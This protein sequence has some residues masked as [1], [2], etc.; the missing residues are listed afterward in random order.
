MRKKIEEHCILNKN[1]L[2]KFIDYLELLEVNDR[3]Y[4]SKIKSDLL[5]D[6]KKAYELLDIVKDLGYLEYNYELYCS[7]CERFL[8][9]E[10]L[11][12]LSQFKP[13]YCDE[14]HSLNP[15]NDTIVIYRVIKV[16]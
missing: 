13:V 1:Q 9:I 12:S 7:K 14:N 5:I 3:V 10:P 15:I 6:Y 2:E 8:D 16:E 4:P 11:K